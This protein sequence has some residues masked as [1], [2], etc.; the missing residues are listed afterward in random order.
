MK[1]WKHWPYW[2]R[3]GVIG[4]GVALVSAILSRLCG[5]LFVTQGYGGLGLE[6]FPFSIP[7]IPF[8]FTLPGSLWIFELPSVVYLSIGIIIWFLV[9]SLVGA[10]VGYIKIK[11]SQQ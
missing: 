9:G 10:L 2:L 1:S 6:C 7:W 5:F 11:K 4:G 8:L 3:G